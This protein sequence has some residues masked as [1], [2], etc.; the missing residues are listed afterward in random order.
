MKRPLLT[1][2]LFYAG[3]IAA[4]SASGSMLF[5]ICC[6][7]FAV[8]LFY[9][10]KRKFPERIKW[11]FIALCF[12]AAGAVQ[13]SV[14]TENIEAKY[15]NMEGEWVTVTGYIDSEPEIRESSIS[16]TI[17]VLN[18]ASDTDSVHKNG[19]ILLTAASKQ[20]GYIYDYGRKII[21]S[22]KLELPKG[23][24]NPGGFNYKK[25]MTGKGLSALVYSREGNIKAAEGSYGGVLKRFGLSIRQQIIKNVNKSV[26]GSEH[27]GLLNGM[28]I[29]SMEGFSEEL[30]DIFSNAGLSHL[31]AVSGAN[32][33][34]LMAPLVFLFKRLGMAR[35]FY[36]ILIIIVLGLFTLVT[37]FEPSV[38]RAVIMAD[39]ILLGNI[40]L[41]NTDIITSISA[42]AF[43]LMLADPC[44]LFNIGFQLSFAATVSIVLFYG[45]I[46]RFIS[47]RYLPQSLCSLI[48]ITV[49]AQIGVIP[50]TLCYFNRLSL[51]SLFTNLA[52]VPAAGFVTV[53]GL[54]TAIVCP[55]S[56]FLAKVAGCITYLPLSLILETAKLSDKIPFASIQVPTPGIIQVISYYLSIWFFLWYKP[57]KKLVLSLK[58][59]VL[60][61]I[62]VLSV[63]FSYI[64]I[65]SGIEAVFLDVGQG[66]SCFVRTAAGRN[67]LID[68]G[69]SGDGKS[70]DQGES[71]VIPFLLDKGVHKLDMVIATHGHDDHIG[72]L[73]SVLDAYNADYLLL[74][75]N[76]DPA[77]F[78]ELKR[79]SETKGIKLHLCSAGEKIELDKNTYLIVLWTAK[80]YKSGAPSLNN[81]SLVLKLVYH[82]FDILFTGDIEK[83]AEIQLVETRRNLAA[84]FLKVPHH[85]SSTS[86]IQEFIDAVNPKAAV[87]SV[88]R[89]NFGHPSMETVDRLEE[90]GIKVYRTDENGAVRLISKGSTFILERTTVR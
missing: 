23:Q 12:F 43:L 81:G 17:Y 86:S 24:R 68:G 56:P 44:I 9:S 40:A 46:K 1:I 88:G 90:N 31:T 83:D 61:S 53:M 21:F 75:D 85:G 38:L 77:E 76:S 10:L 33:A 28:I 26:P 62:C 79:I 65:Q 22:G 7:V 4:A 45:S 25:Y 84:D 89:N 67:I 14:Y 57:Q 11:I 48:S 72:G 64:S 63:T 70:G 32:I 20:K 58:Q 2:T 59:L 15:R 37:G 55:L 60:P 80:D 36:S 78:E 54:L 69:S 5:A 13:F 73:K 87:I 30:K 8:V 50:V 19:R 27:A 29:G 16:Y 74:P 34:Y 18:I 35:R 47:F 41:R 6:A 66:D 51:I 71:V 39:I 52:A 42:S 82:D 3:G 49:A